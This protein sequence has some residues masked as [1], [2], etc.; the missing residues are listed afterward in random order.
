MLPVKLLIRVPILRWMG[1]EQPELPHHALWQVELNRPIAYQ[2]AAHEPETLV[3][4]ALRVQRK[5]IQ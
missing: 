1:L 3:L 2:R 5:F 4:Q